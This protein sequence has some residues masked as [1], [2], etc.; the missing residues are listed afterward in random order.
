MAKVLVTGGAGFIGSHIVDRLIADEHEV[1][2]IDNLSTGKK[3]NLN[4]KAE[5]HKADIADYDSIKDLFNGVDV[6]FH[7]AALARLTPSIKNPVPAHKANVDGTFNVLWASNSSKVSKFIFSSTSSLYGDQAPESYPL[8]ETVPVRFKSPYTA[9]KLMGEIYCELFSKI[10][11][12][13]TLILRY[14]NVY[15]PRQITEG[16]YATVVGIFLRQRELGLPLTIV[17]DAGERRRD[18]THVFDIVE[19]N[20]LAW[21]KDVAGAEIINLGCGKNYS[22]NQVAGL[23]GGPTVKI[24]PR[25]WDAAIT[26]ADNSKARQLLGWE[27]KISFEDGMAELKKLHGIS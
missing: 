1:I 13:P 18:Y 22:V 15:G 12:L 3:E 4:P 6:V 2:V 19:G 25:P 16:T 21:K 14:F 17:S 10:Y 26:L 27:P 7:V 20:M 24:E 23:I 5:F 8:K 11:A 9:Q